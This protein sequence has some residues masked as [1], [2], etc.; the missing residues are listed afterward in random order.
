MYGM[1]SSGTKLAAFF[2]THYPV[3]S[4]CED[5]DKNTA[6]VN[7][8]T[9]KFFGFKLNDLFKEIRPIPYSSIDYGLIYSGKPVLLEQIAGNQ[10]K[11]NAISTKEIK[12]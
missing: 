5:F 11:S 9:K 3:V 4:F 7:V 8:T 1:V 6:H 10:Y 2:D 12:T